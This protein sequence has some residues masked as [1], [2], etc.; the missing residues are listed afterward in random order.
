MQSQ[1]EDFLKLKAS[2]LKATQALQDKVASLTESLAQ[3]ATEVDDH[4]RDLV[5]S[6]KKCE[7]L[8]R[9]VDRLLDIVIEREHEADAS[10]EALAQMRRVL[11]ERNHVLQARIKALARELSLRRTDLAVAQAQINKLSKTVAQKESVLAEKVEHLGKSTLRVESLQNRV[12]ALNSTLARK[13]RELASAE[14]LQDKV[15]RLST[16]LED[17]D[18]ELTTQS[19]DL[20]RTTRRAEI[21]QKRVNT[22]NGKLEIAEKKISR[23]NALENQVKQLT[24]ALKAKE[25]ALADKG[26]KLSKSIGQQENL[27]DRV[28]TLEQTLTSKSEQLDQADV[29]LAQR[30]KHLDDA[31][32]QLAASS[33]RSSILQKRINTLNGL[34][35]EKETELVE[36]TGGPTARDKVKKLTNA[37]A[38]KERELTAESKKLSESARQLEN[39]KSQCNALDNTLTQKKT[40][41]SGQLTVAYNR[42][43]ALKSR[44]EVLDIAV[45]E[46][47]RELVNARNLQ[48]R[49]EVCYVLCWWSVLN[50]SILMPLVKFEKAYFRNSP[51]EVHRSLP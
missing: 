11:G 9:S 43:K 25:R 7:N 32:A 38:A 49:V 47:D 1:V 4:S 31:N 44:V 16:V 22:L 20:L 17:K 30:E 10:R 2:E 8:Q 42:V 18:R 36:L 29:I 28:D 50:R 14:H 12:N 33:G 15:D 34:L 21:L 35:V 5:Q 23:G 37:L 46:K 51:I 40:L 13:E 39:L 6:T 27:Q 48:K 41:Y 45:R 26:E 24:S 19:K 3:K